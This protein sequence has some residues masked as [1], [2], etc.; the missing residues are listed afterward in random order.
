[1][2]K[3]P[4]IGFLAPIRGLRISKSIRRGPIPNNYFLER[5]LCLWHQLDAS[6]IVVQKFITGNTFWLVLCYVV[7]TQAQKYIG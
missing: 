1:M 5:S 4:L 2:G 7:A 3:G 6:V